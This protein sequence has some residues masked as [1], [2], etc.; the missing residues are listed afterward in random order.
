MGSLLS[1]S[2]FFGS[3]PVEEM[4][5]EYGF[6]DVSAEVGVDK[7]G[8]TDSTTGL[9]NACYKAKEADQTAYFP[10]GTYRVTD[11]IYLNHIDSN[12][13]CGGS[14][15]DTD[16][17]VLVGSKVGA[18][19]VIKLDD[20]ATGFQ[21]SGNPREVLRLRHSVSDGTEKEGCCFGFGIRNIDIDCGSGNEGAIGLWF[22]AAQDSFIEDVKVEVRDGF[23][24]F[25][26]IPGAA[27]ATQN[28]EAVGGQYGL[29]LLG[30]SLGASIVGFKASGQ[31]EAAIYARV[32]RGMQITGFDIQASSGP[33]LT[34][35]GSSGEEGNI[36]FLDGKID[37]DTNSTAITNADL[38]FVSLRN[39]YLNRAGTVINSGGNAFTGNATGWTRVIQY[40]YCP[41]T[42]ASTLDGCENLIDGVGNTSSG[43][44]KETPGSVPINLVGKHI[45]AGSPE[46]KDTRV[47][48]VVDAGV[49]P[50]TGL[51]VWQELQDI[52]DA[53]DYVFF[54][55]GVYDTS[56]PLVLHANSHIFGVPGRR[57]IVR[58]TDAW[59][60]G[61]SARAYIFDTVDNASATT[62][63]EHM[64]VDWND[65]S[66]DSWIGGVRWRVGRNSVWRQI[67]AERVSSRDA[68]EPRHIYHIEGNG[69]GRWYSF[70]EHMNVNSGDAPDYN[71]DFRKLY[72][73][74]TT[75]PLTIYGL[76]VE[77]GSDADRVVNGPF[78][79]VVGAQNVRFLG[80]K[81][82]ANGTIILVTPS[83]D[84]TPVESSNIYM[85]SMWANPYYRGDFAHIDFETADIEID[86][87]AWGNGQSTEFVAKEIGYTGDTVSREYMLGTYG[88]GTVDFSVWE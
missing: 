87:M 62:T 58:G 53:N 59:T 76:N 25:R 70:I 77:H 56:A 26:N 38:R 21:D 72:I 80:C 60:G 9:I 7:T 73:S 33:I 27:A 84:G 52:I 43:G 29:Y 45:W 30:G 13:I 49:D 83:T 63:L 54:P 50:D 3:A 81:T 24:G 23:C 41:A 74:E 78:V 75:E 4:D 36:T 55:A 51:D 31:S 69:G 37:L 44:T 88:R 46:Y 79:E 16:V 32:W 67:R 19:P 42:F 39:V 11:R 15:N 28:I 35:D 5:T 68:D 48:N 22:N 64:V 17:F 2:F 8:I 1:S 34:T 61:L 47:T 18:R 57:S 10:S 66:V 82:E 12:A 14:H 6:L 65:Y 71:S 40:S 86:M 20:N 85:A